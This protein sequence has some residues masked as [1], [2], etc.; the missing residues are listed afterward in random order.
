MFDAYITPILVYNC[1]TWALTKTTKD[2]LNSFHGVFSVDSS[3]YFGLKT[4]NKDLYLATK[5]HEL[6]KNIRL[7]KLT[8]LSHISRLDSCTHDQK[9]MSKHFDAPFTPTKGRLKATLASVLRM[10]LKSM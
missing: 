3:V 9:A 2:R 4:N 6:S 8:L 7:R 10:D 1:G 5:L